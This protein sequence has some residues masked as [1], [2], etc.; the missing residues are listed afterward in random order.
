MSPVRRLL[1]A[2]VVPAVLVGAAGCSE[3]GGPTQEQYAS[4]ADDV[5]EDA[6]ED[7][8]GVY[9]DQAVEEL[10]A[11]LAGE[12]TPVYVD[13]PDRWVRAKV[14]PAYERLSSRLKSIPPP[15]GDVAYL[16]DLYG[17][18]DARIEVLHRR[19]G[20]G[21]AAVEADTLLRDRFASYGMETCPP[22]ADE[23]PDYED[24]AK[25]LEALQEA[26]ADPADPAEEEAGGEGQ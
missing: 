20:D 17:D 4:M 3:G 12:G 6:K 19:P 22:K 24:P 16:S 5:C 1:L 14:V 8:D 15:D 2:L 25:V 18:L 9:M 7:I 13:R 23:V 10:R 11:S 26:D 21:R